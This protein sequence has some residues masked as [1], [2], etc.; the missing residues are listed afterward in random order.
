[1]S[2]AT[3]GECYKSSIM[4][5]PRGIET[6]TI[7]ISVTN[8]DLRRLERRARRLYGGNISAVIHEIA[9]HAERQDAIDRLWSSLGEPTVTDK[10]RKAIMAEWSS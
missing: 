10:E 2:P 6:R 9:E 7:S 8:E 4:R 3:E 5:R 1:M